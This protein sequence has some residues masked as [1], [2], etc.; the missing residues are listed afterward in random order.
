[1]SRV[2]GKEPAANEASRR[3][4]RLRGGSGRAGEEG[5]GG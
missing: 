2:R 1:M 5:T 3:A 4:G